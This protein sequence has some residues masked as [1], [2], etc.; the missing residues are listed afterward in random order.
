MEAA[1]CDLTNTTSRTEN[2]GSKES[3][4]VTNA[5]STPSRKVNVIEPIYKSDVDEVDDVF[6]PDGTGQVPAVNLS[7]ELDELNLE[8]SR[9]QTVPSKR[10]TK[11]IPGDHDE[12]PMEGFMKITDIAGEFKS[13]E[14]IDFPPL[15]YSKDIICRTLAASVAVYC[16]TQRSQPDM[17]RLIYAM[18]VLKHDIMYEECKKTLLDHN[19]T[20]LMF[21]ILSQ[22][23]IAPWRVSIKHTLGVLHILSQDGSTNH[24]FLA[25]LLDWKC[26]YQ[27]CNR[28]FGAMIALLHGETR[29][30]NGQRHANFISG[31]SSLETKLLSE[32][33]LVIEVSSFLSMI[34]QRMTTLKSTR[35]KL[36]KLN[37]KHGLVNEMFEVENCILQFIKHRS[38]NETDIDDE[39]EFHFFIMNA[40]AISKHITP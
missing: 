9:A 17:R 39:K 38:Q 37:R 13:S 33:N 6:D 26:F 35:I 30:A 14:L 32:H 15:I 24:Q 36:I 23:M 10:A 27:V 12:I 20:P 5:S 34:L 18:Q 4:S 21:Q 8:E 11:E 2:V 29:A 22:A 19:I 28:I 7:R 3:I 31:R 16:E 40:K 1:L 25:N